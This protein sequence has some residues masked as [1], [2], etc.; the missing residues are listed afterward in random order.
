MCFR[1]TPFTA[2]QQGD[3]NDLLR[4]SVPVQINRVI[5]IH[6]QNLDVRLNTS[7]ERVEGVRLRVFF[8]EVRVLLHC[9][10]TRIF[11]NRYKMFVRSSAGTPLVICGRDRS[12]V[13]FFDNNYHPLGSLGSLAFNKAP[14]DV[15]RGLVERRGQLGQR[16][17]I[18]T[19]DEFPVLV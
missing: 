12:F 6:I 3:I 8:V 16:G 13:Y 11:A 15:I 14:N 10:S 17:Y 9:S 4:V 18:G 19:F 7:L 2:L 5:I 1:E